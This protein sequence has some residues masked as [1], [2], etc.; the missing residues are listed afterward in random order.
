MPSP[1]LVLLLWVPVASKS[2][3]CAQS[4]EASE[5]AEAHEEWADELAP[6]AQVGG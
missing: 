3:R 4:Q 6:E 2:Q 1:S 5:L